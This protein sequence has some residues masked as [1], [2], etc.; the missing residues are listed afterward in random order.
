MCQ[1]IKTITSNVFTTYI[2]HLSGRGVR[3]IIV[4]SVL[5]KKNILPL[6]RVYVYKQTFYKEISEFFCLFGTHKI[7]HNDIVFDTFSTK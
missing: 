5:P 1:P 7:G 3:L 2:Y 4:T 6:P